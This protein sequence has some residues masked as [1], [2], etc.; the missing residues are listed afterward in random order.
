M[1]NR[2]RVNA[3]ILL[4][5]FNTTFLSAISD[6]NLSIDATS[7]DFEQ[8][9]QTEYIPASHIANNVNKASSAVAVV[10]AQDIKDYGYRT[11]G[12]ILGSMRG[13]QVFQNYHYNFLGGRG[14][15]APGEYAGRIAVLIDGYRADDALYGQ[16]YFGRDG[17]LDVAM[18]DRVE[19]IPGG[20]SAGYSSG[21]LLGVINII[22]KEGN[23][24]DGGEFAV[25]YGNHN[26]KTKRA[27][28][29]K[30]FDD[31]LEIL[32]D[33]SRYNGDGRSFTYNIDGV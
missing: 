33:A 15:S 6:Q 29:G 28:F 18:I 1:F 26:S 30:K 3:L 27:S 25:G 8:L 10:T 4:L 23:D 22:T 20:G 31:G 11:L 5:F 21:A 9:L 17:L 13:L 16:T 2:I 14:F 24:I 12:E 19:Y 7:I 32:L